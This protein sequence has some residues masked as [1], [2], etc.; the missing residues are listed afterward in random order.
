MDLL[1]GLRL[2]LFLMDLIDGLR[3]GLFTMVLLD[4]RVRRLIFE[5]WR[6]MDCVWDHLQWIAFGILYDGLCLESFLMDVI[7]GLRLGLLR[8]V[9][10][11]GCV[12]Q[13]IFE[14]WCWLN[15]VWDYLRWI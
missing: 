3:L 9:L 4:G 13:L 10:L 12:R 14:L 2:G 6:W 5:L 15:C 11:G 1:D 8:T 7:D